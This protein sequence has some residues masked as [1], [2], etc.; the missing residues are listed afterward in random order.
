[1]PNVEHGANIGA[2]IWYSWTTTAQHSVILTNAK[3]TESP[4]VGHQRQN[5]KEQKQ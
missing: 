3:A 2:A 1:M 4:R 5:D